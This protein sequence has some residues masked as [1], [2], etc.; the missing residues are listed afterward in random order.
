MH[1]A[2]AIK[3]RDLRLEIR[4]IWSGASRDRPRDVVWLDFMVPQWHLALDVTV[5]RARMNSNVPA[6]GASLPLHGSLDMGA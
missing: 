3:R 5:T 4:R 1:E 6:V 2:G